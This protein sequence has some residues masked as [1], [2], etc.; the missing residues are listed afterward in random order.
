MAG[1]DRWPGWEPN[2]LSTTGNL[3]GGHGLQA[4]RTWHPLT[5]P[6]PNCPVGPSRLQKD[7]ASLAG[8]LRPFLALKLEDCPGPAF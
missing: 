4:G 5:G 7:L 8:Q 6:E 1:R 3:L 2:G